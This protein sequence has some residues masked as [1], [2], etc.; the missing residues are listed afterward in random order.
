MTDRTDI[1]SCISCG[2]RFVY[3]FP[4]GD[5]SGRFCS[6]RCQEYYDAGGQPPQEIED[7]GI[8]NWKV[9]AGPLTGDPYTDIIA[10]SDRKRSAAAGQ[11]ELIRP[12]RFCARC[13]G[14]IPVWKDGREV[15][16]RRRFCFICEPK[17]TA[18][19]HRHRSRGIS[20]KKAA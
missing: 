1:V 16:S 11:D 7:H 12:K 17:N 13:G 2:Q 14:R 10:A 20:P 5:N 9:I 4:E 6:V 3:K 19:A 8:R 15:Q 18:K